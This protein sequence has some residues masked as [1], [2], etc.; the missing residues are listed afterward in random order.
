MNSPPLKGVHIHLNIFKRKR[1]LD[2][3]L[4]HNNIVLNSEFVEYFRLTKLQRLLIKLLILHGPAS[5]FRLTKL[6][7]RHYESTWRS[8]KYLESKGLVRVAKTKKGSTNRTKTLYEITGVAFQGLLNIDL[9][10][11]WQMGSW[12]YAIREICQDAL[13]EVLVY[14]PKEDK[15]SRVVVPLKEEY[16][17]LARKT[18]QT[19][20]SESSEPL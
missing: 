15:L 17:E 9:S 11:A 6:A 4:S 8:L 13:L 10:V 20:P 5:A 19:M 3:A 18:A 1:E 2:L 14:L 16:M 12:I 7:R